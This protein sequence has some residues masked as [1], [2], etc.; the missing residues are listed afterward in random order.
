[1][2][3]INADKTGT[4]TFPFDPRLGEVLWTH[5]GRKMAIV[6]HDSDAP[7]DF[8]EIAITDI[9]TGS[10]FTLNEGSK[11]AWSLDGTRVSFASQYS[12]GK[13]FSLSVMDPDGTYL[14]EFNDGFNA[15]C[16]GVWS[17]DGRRMAFFSSDRDGNHNLYVKDADGAN[18]KQLID[19]Y[20]SY[21]C[22]VWS[23]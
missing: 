13:G 19:G 6:S 11:S 22:P 8:S 21:N 2:L 20:Y 10:I 17:A 7:G 16:G 4:L 12:V 1:M 18:L 3:V 14:L 23:P 5:D 9:E 15:R